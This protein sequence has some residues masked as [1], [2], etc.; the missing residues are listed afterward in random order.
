MLY[1]LVRPM[2]RKGSSKQQFKQRIPAD[3]QA[4][5]VGL[6][7]DIPVGAET[8]PL[9]ITANAE[10]VRLSLRASNPSDVKSRQAQVAAYLEGVWEALRKQQPLPLTHRQTV[11][12]AGEL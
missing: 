9:T 4:R 7:L 8:I 2:R 5:A 3:V 11:A 10:A 1:R 12:L 6:K